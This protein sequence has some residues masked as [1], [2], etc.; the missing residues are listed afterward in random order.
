MHWSYVVGSL[1]AHL[2]FNRWEPRSL[3]VRLGLLLGIPTFNSV[4][5]N[6]YDPLALLAA[7]S[8]HVAIL[9]GSLFL[10]RRNPKHPLASYPGPFLATLTNLWMAYQSSGGKRH[11][12]LREL[13]QKYGTHVRIGP[14]MLSIVDVDVVT[15]LLHDPKVPRSSGYRAIEADHVPGH[16]ISCRSISVPNHLKLHSEK[17][18]AWGKGFTSSALDEFNVALNTRLTQLLEKLRSHAESHTAVNLD[19]WIKYFI[20]DFMGDLVLG[21]GFSMIQ[22]GEDKSGFRSI[23]EQAL[24]AQTSIVYMPWAN[25]LIPYLAALGDS[26]R[27]MLQFAD[28]CITERSRQPLAV[29]DL[30]YFFAK[31]DE[32]EHLRPSR[33]ANVNDV[34]LG[35]G[36][37]ADTTVL[38]LSSLFFL[39]FAHPEKFRVL[40]EEIDSLDESEST[41]LTRLAHLPYLNA[42]IDE[43]LRLFPP[44][45]TQLSRTPANGHG[46]VIGGR[47][48]PD[49][50]TVYIA[51]LLLGRDPR[52]FSPHTTSFW[53]ERWLSSERA[54]N[55]GIIHNTQAFIPFS[56][57]VTLCLGKQLA[58]RELRLATTTLIRNFNMK[59]VLDEGLSE[60]PRI[61]EVLESISDWAT[62][63]FEKG[64][65]RVE[66][67]NRI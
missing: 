53:P 21:G 34:F 67:E 50:T 37:G 46:N 6:G 14:N 63:S 22:D 24:I 25:N 55:P 13:H 65:V 62:F 5:V 28:K 38:T 12:V 42:C 1:L 41:N 26:Q 30:F 20:W 4:R 35:I 27:K 11:I 10:Y 56:A 40:R 60:P 66:L 36:A 32:P 2:V 18:E 9:I 33:A 43:T 58:Y 23:L 47:Y 17:R 52:Y 45:L 19:E 16:L 7:I 57:G 44:L 59:F 31:E 29:K 15:K 61:E 39:L 48:V 64:F 49:G 54:K 51:P 8:I 3:K